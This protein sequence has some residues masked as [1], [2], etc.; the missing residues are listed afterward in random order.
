M[1]LI[2]LELPLLTADLRFQTLPCSQLALPPPSVL[3]PSAA[4]HLAGLCSPSL[5]I[6]SLS[7]VH[8]CVLEPEFESFPLPILKIHRDI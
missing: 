8:S 1:S 4:H 7:F 5:F 3:Q 6:P 2:S